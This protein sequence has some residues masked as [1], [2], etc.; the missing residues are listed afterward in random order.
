MCGG[1]FEPREEVD[2][3]A[4]KKEKSKKD[5]KRDSKPRKE[6]SPRW[7]AWRPPRHPRGQAPEVTLTD[8]DCPV[9]AF[10]TSR[11][12][13]PGLET[14]EPLETRAQYPSR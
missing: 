9:E 4:K 13:L 6:C 8:T 14:T 1:P 2:A 5:I 10:A 3:M 7:V 11:N 12:S